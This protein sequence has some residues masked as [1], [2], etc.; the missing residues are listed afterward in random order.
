MALTYLIPFGII[1]LFPSEQRM[2][3]GRPSLHYILPTV[4]Y[5][6]QDTVIEKFRQRLHNL[7]EKGQ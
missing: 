1:P 6:A 7:K 3:I 4:S 5:G 2:Y